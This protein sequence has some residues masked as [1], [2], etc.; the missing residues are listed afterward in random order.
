MTFISCAALQNYSHTSIKRIEL[1][2]FVANRRLC[3]KCVS[4]DVCFDENLSTPQ[5]DLSMQKH[6]II[7]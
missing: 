6:L 4:N 2:Q 1:A 5:I 3:I 7:F